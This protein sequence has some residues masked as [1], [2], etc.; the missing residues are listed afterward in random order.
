MTD[1]LS[2]GSDTQDTLSE[3]VER[4]RS[5]DAGEDGSSNDN[6]SNSDS[7]TTED[8]LFE[9]KKGIFQDKEKVRVGWVPDGSR[10]VGRDNYINKISEALNDSVFGKQP[11]HVAITGKTGTGKSLVS[12]FVAERAKSAA[13]D[14]VNLGV[15][16]IDCSESPTVTQ[17]ISAIGQQLNQSEFYNDPNTSPIR[18]PDAGL[19]KQKFYQRLW[20][21]LNHYDSALVILDEVDLLKEEMV[22]MNLAKAV[23]KQAT[24]CNI[25]I[26]AISN[27][28]GFFD[29]LGPRTK[30]V[31][32]PE[33]I[34]FNPYEAGQLIKILEGRKDAFYDD[35]LTDEVIPLVAALAA[36]EH[37]DARRAM[38]LFRISGE[39]AERENT[40]KVVKNHVYEAQDKVEADRFATFIE[41]TP[42]QMKATALALASHMIWSDENYVLTG[43]VYETY[44][45]LAHTME[46]STISIRR[47]RD[48]LDE[49]ELHQVSE[50]G[51][52]ADGNHNSHRL[53]HNPKIVREV[54]MRD[55]RF[56]S[57]TDSNLRNFVQ[58][59][60]R[61]S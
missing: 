57:L 4:Q 35:V 34:T 22:L 39:L 41:G 52:A 46:L 15:A 28:I 48:I 53:L 44:Q 38:R 1:E 60:Y 43:D 17:L 47:F 33:E 16:Y 20:N 37:G 3:A 54:I 25:G 10:I 6:D 32:Q 29:S 7:P 2:D 56:S 24:T 51:K 45:R 27:M 40:N 18:M 5:K 31:F 30:S 23:E 61:S 26:V 49:M 55:A 13:V 11:Q 8:P 9:Y 58:Q 36:Q 42:T 14:N 12:R 50:V 21:I 59:T 19:S